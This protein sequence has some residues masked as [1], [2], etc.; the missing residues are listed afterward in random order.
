MEISRIQIKN[1]L[2]VSSVDLTPGKVNQ[3]VGG[4]NAGKTTILK[5]LQA[6]LEG[7]TDGTVVKHGEDTA[8]IIIDLDELTIRR[9]IKPDGS[10][11]VSVKTAD[12]SLKAKPQEFLD[13]LINSNAFNPLD[14]LDPKKRTEAL[15]K[16][17]PISVGE[18]E[19]KSALTSLSPI[20]VPPLDYN[21]HGLKVAESAHRYFYQRRH[22]AG[23]IAKEKRAAYEIK[24][25]ELPPPSPEEHL[26]TKEA[27]GAD[28][29][30]AEWPDGKEN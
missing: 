12:G 16:C 13:K 9:R 15:L 29:A 26:P 22:E 24:E 17:I 3:I 6:G 4:N 11:S 18:G 7:T 27:L 20:D 10:Q 5:A 25:K 1:F 19:L 23:R 2:S 21:Q 14:L 28:I 8:E 30:A